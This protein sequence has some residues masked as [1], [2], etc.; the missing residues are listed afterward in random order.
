M[1]VSQEK[2]LPM[3]YTGNTRGLAIHQ[4]MVYIYAHIL[5]SLTLDVRLAE[6]TIRIG[7]VTLVRT[8]LRCL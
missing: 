6:E 5:H 8:L 4:E 1:W 2:G 3:I 7:V